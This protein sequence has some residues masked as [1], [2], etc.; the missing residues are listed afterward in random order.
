MI[1]ENKQK[2]K[3]RRIRDTKQRRK[4]S[5]KNRNGVN[6]KLKSIIH[7]KEKIRKNKKI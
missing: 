4:K 7:F 5:A 1:I 3:E 2:V 6:K